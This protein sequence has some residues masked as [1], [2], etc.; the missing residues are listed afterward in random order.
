MNANA[1]RYM[2]IAHER[3]RVNQARNLSVLKKKYRYMNILWTEE[4]EAETLARIS[5]ENR[6]ARYLNQYRDT[7]RTEYPGWGDW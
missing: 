6:L 4:I 5:N 2:E 3:H 1:I 7:N